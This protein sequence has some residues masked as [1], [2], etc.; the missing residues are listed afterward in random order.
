MSVSVNSNNRG[1]ALWQL[2]YLLISFAQNWCLKERC[3]WS[4]GLYAP[5]RVKSCDGV[6]IRTA[7]ARCSNITI[8]LTRALCRNDLCTSIVTPVKVSVPVDPDGR[9]NNM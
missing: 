1:G 7:S 8:L 5:I 3:R 6:L 9:L 4:P 2:P